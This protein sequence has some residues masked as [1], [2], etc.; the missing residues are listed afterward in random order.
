[1]TLIIG[2]Q[3]IPFRLKNVDGKPVS[4][5]DLAKGAK[6]LAVIFSC[7]HCPY[8][9][10]WE[11]RMIGLGKTYQAKGVAFALINAND[12]KKYSE[13]GFPEMV[14]R[15][16]AKGYPFPYLHDETQET[17][18]AYGATRTPE[19][20]LFD[21]QRALR[22]HGRI[23]DNYENPQAVRSH[24]FREALEAVLAGRAPATADTPLAGC[25]IKWK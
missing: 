18:R 8:V 21:S 17:A 16:K 14:K 22:Y 2:G 4:S 5:D 24:D 13:D 10:A 11:D 15:A 23:D 25:T 12:P 6:A 7:N 9:Q 19:V 3:L 20:F 1:M